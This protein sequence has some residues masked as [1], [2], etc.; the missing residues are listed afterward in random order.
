[1]YALL[2]SEHYG[3]HWPAIVTVPLVVAATSL[4]GL[5]LGVPSRRLLGDYLAIVALP[6]VRRRRL[7]E[8]VDPQVAGTGLTGGPNRI[9][10]IDPVSI[11]GYEFVTRT[12]QYFML[13]VAGS[14]S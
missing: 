14:S 9:A 11:F 12:Q 6:S 4:L 2:S 5:F 1:M 8:R 10:D 7:R 3:I 13:L